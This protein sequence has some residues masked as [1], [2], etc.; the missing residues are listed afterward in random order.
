MELLP[1]GALSFIDAVN[2]A[3]RLA[4]MYLKPAYGVANLLG[5]TALNLVQQGWAA[6]R[7]LK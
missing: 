7:N 1:E 2:N 3:T 5:N 6:P 4:A